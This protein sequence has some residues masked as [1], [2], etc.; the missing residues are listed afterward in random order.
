VT[1]LKPVEAMALGKPVVLSDLPA[2]SELVGADGAGLLVPPGDPA[3][4]A[5]ALAA[6]RDDPERRRVMGEAGRAEVAARRTWSSLARTY[7]G[8]YETL[9]KSR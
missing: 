4:F 2:L 1:P 9:A 6:L 3:A 8:I 7:R 5:K